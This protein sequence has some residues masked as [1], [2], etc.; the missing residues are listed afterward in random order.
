M[1]EDTKFEDESFDLSEIEGT[2]GQPIFLHDGT[3]I[4]DSSGIS[5]KKY[6]FTNP[7]VL[8]DADLSKLKTKSEQFAYYLAGH[9]SM[10]LRIEFNLE[11]DD[12]TADL[13][14]N[15]TQSIK[16]PSC[17]SMF[18]MQELNGVC[19]LD[20]NSHLSATVVDRILGGRG[21][22]NPEERGLTDI[23]KALVEDFNQIIL[24]EWCKQWE[25]T[26]SLTPSII[27]SESS[28]KFLQTSPADAM[29]LIMSMEASFGDVS[30]PMRIAVPYY[31]MEPVLSRL[32]A[33]V[34]SEETKTTRPPRWHEV[35]D[36]IP[37]QV[38]A[39]WDAFELSLRDLSN[40]EVDDIIEMDSALIEKTKLRI[41]SRTCFTGEI[42]LEG[43]QV[44]FQ[45]NESIT[46]ALKMIGKNHG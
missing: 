20:V 17:V 29:M 1:P 34:S 16:T 43:D 27:G 10:F 14:S 3:K 28:G 46:D 24:Q 36:N 6:D 22:T 9:L 4:L 44:A 40:L 12:L 45:V 30:G 31:T 8:S 19:L 18:K 11:L 32:L 35:Y 33:S 2:S 13:Y 23:E 5:S 21:S 37:V 42:G 39:E 15:F 26:M 41:E 25:S 38:S 7:I